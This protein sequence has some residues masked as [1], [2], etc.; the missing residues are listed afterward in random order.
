M[1]L[2]WIFYRSIQ[3]F[4]LNINSKVKDRERKD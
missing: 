3:L 4:L 2:L 1:F